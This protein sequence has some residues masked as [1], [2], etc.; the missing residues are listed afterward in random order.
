MLS[1]QAETE[2]GGGGEDPGEE[3]ARDRGARQGSPFSAQAALQQTRAILSSTQ[4]H[5]RAVLSSVRDAAWWKGALESLR[6]PAR[7]QGQGG[8]DGDTREANAGFGRQG[9]HP[10]YEDVMDDGYLS[11]V[12]FF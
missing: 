6:R 10:F 9:C 8:E 4:R 12:S 3:G 1:Q 11:V 2:A 5:T 7:T